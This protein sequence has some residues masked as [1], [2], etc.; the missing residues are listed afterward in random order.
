MKLYTK[1]TVSCDYHPIKEFS[2]EGI[3]RE[4]YLTYVS[5]LD[6]EWHRRIEVDSNDLAEITYP[7]LKDLV[8][9][10]GLFRIEMNHVPE[11]TIHLTFYFSKT[12][13]NLNHHLGKVFEANSTKDFKVW[14]SQDLV[15]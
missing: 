3:F 10:Y 4:C 15:E 9:E 1:L 13:C 7:M 14:E 12:E 5:L 6:K 8:A 11:D 2:R